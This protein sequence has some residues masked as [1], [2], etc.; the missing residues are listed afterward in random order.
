M[1]AGNASDL[2][3][4]SSLKKTIVYVV[5]AV[6]VCLF[7]G[8]AYLMM[9]GDAGS[10]DVAMR[11]VTDS[12]GKEMQ[13]PVHPKR[14]VFLNVSN[15]DMYVA[16]GG[17]DAI[18]GKPTSTSMSPELAK[19]VE[20]AQEVGI[21]HSPNIEKI[22]ALKPDLV[23]GVNVP[24]H[25]QLRE[26][27][28]QNHIPL[29]INSLDS[30]EDTLK[31]M[32]FFGELTGQE[33]TAKAAIE[34]IT[35]QCSDA[36][37]MTA[38]KQGPKTLILFSNPD[39]NNMASSTT[40]SGDLLKRLHGV[41]I[42][43]LDTSLKGQFIPLSLEYVV[44]QDPEVIFIISMGNT[45]DSLARFKDQMQTNEAW[46]Q[47]A[48]VKNGRIYELPMDLFTVNPGSRIGDAMMYMADCLYGQGGK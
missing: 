13:I 16:A 37:A 23:I 25:N 24:F 15:M 10:S 32:K 44:K 48:A 34:K 12:T 11:Q 5:L 47:T 6:V 7:G 35:K 46:N 43:D 20:P 33:D 26:T 2:Q 38:G 18:V 29:Y 21:I 40:F 1:R 27:M 36:E 41:N 22:L 42:A 8:I 31:T 45:P 9:R 39:S 17:K 3:G 19:A 14:I 28:E 30:Y 4:G